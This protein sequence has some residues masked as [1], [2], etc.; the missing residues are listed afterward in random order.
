MRQRGAMAI[1]DDGGH[2]VA[3]EQNQD[4]LKSLVSSR[5]LIV[6]EEM[7]SGRDLKLTGERGGW[8][9]LAEVFWKSDSFPKSWSN[10]C[11][12]AVGTFKRG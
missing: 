5:G 9:K 8:G 4:S 1:G 11:Q 6:V 3:R 2:V 10:K 7:A 12:R